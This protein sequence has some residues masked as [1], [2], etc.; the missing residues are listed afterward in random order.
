MRPLMILLHIS[1][2]GLLSAGAFLLLWSLAA[3]VGM[4]RHVWLFSIPALAV[5]VPFHFMLRASVLRSTLTVLLSL[6]SISLLLLYASPNTPALIGS[7]VVATVATYCVFVFAA[8][9][10]AKAIPAA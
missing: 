2:C 3:A 1:F 9:R 4:D 6:A 5:A 10:Q 7:M 8:R